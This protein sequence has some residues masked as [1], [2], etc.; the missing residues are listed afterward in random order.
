MLIQILDHD[1]RAVTV[2]H[3]I[4]SANIVITANERSEAQFI[5]P[6][7]L[8]EL[9]ASNV[10]TL[11]RMR[12]YDGQGRLRFNGYVSA[13]LPGDDETQ[14]T[15]VDLSEELRLIPLPPVAILNGY[16]ATIFPK[17]LSYAPAVN[18]IRWAMG[19]IS[20]AIN[21]WTMIDASKLSCFEAM[22]TLCDQTGNWFR[23]RNRLV[24]L[25][26]EPLQETPS[27]FIFQGNPLARKPTDAS[28][29]S[30]IVGQLSIETVSDQ[31][32]AGVFPEGSSYQDNTNMSR[33]LR[34]S[35]SENVPDGYILANLWGYWGVFDQEK[36]GP[37]PLSVLPLGLVRSEVFSSI[38]PIINMDE[39]VDG[40][41]EKM[42]GST[43][44][45][46][47][48]D[49]F[50]SDHWKTAKAT[51][52]NYE[53]TVT[54]SHD[55]QVTLASVLPLTIG[56]HLNLSVFRPWSLPGLIEAQ[57]SLATAAVAFLRDRRDAQ[58]LIRAT[59]APSDTVL[60]PGDKLH[61]R[62]AGG[63]TLTYR[64]QERYVEAIKIAG[65]YAISNVTLSLDQGIETE[66]YAMSS[67]LWRW[68]SASGLR[69]IMSVLARRMP[70][71]ASA[72]GQGYTAQ[73]IV[74]CGPDSS[75]CAVE[76]RLGT[77]FFGVTFVEPPTITAV[78]VLAS[79]YIASANTTTVSVSVCLSGAIISSD[80]SVRVT[81]IVGPTVNNAL[82]EQAER[83]HVSAAAI[84]IE[85]IYN[86]FSSNE[87]EGALHEVSSGAAISDKAVTLRHVDFG[88]SDQQVN[89]KV[90]PYANERRLMAADNVEAAINELFEIAQHPDV[91]GRLVS[92]TTSVAQDDTHIVCDSA[93]AMD[94]NLS[95]AYGSWRTLT[96]SSIGA[97]AVSVIASVPDVISGGPSIALA[98]YETVQIRDYAAGAW[99]VIARS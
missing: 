39:S 72:N 18:G 26:A 79:G 87:V 66:T 50:E 20:K 5:I 45:A 1:E 65:E 24:D 59:V 80:I 34:L 29:T 98:Q 94:V 30:Q 11:S 67:N 43:V 23:F 84:A 68:P 99:V 33:V 51:S 89:S 7:A 41:V 55:D 53:T 37:S 48:F 40:V 78:E 64:S 81:I 46:A 15:A 71:A 17:I 85:D 3:R 22:V 21:S 52:G 74:T 25:Y 88:L 2:L 82:A 12:A 6:S 75:L 86:A 44:T 28:P 10:T 77:T 16:V 54:G 9:H 8:P 36:T 58:I 60:L 93:D 90:I 92:D 31:I 47:A 97:G 4:T 38:Y 76:G 63:V 13:I 95:P 70:N 61:L 14:I 35:G 49:G 83:G 91:V 57:Q 19:D 69:E 42:A 32:Y 56:D 62:Y 27:L 73:F 96:L